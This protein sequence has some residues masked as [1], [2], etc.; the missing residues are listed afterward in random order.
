MIVLMPFTQ[1]FSARTWDWAQVLLVGAI[2][3]PGK[4]TVTAALRVLGLKDDKQYQNY[5]RVLN[6]AKWSG[7]QVSQ[8]LLGILV[9]TFVG[10]GVPIVLGADETLERRRGTKIK[11]KGIFRDAVRSSHKYTNYSSGLRWV[12]MMLLVSVPWS[13][14]VGA[15]PFLT[16]LAPSPKTNESNGRRHKTSIDWVGQMVGVVRRWLRQRELVLVV[17]GAMAAVKLGLRCAGYVRPVILVTRL[18]LDAVLHR[19]P[20]PQPKSKRGP[21]PKKGAR[22]P[23]LAQVLAG[24]ATIWI[25]QNIAWYG[26]RQRLIEYVTGTALWYTPGYDPLPIRW[27]LVRDPLGEFKPTAFFTTDQTAGPVQILDWFIMRWGLEVTFEEV[28]AHLGLETQR[29]WSGTSRPSQPSLM[30]LLWSGI[31]FGQP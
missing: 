10:V 24:P 26:G 11:A 18:R 20:G 27:V 4:R 7:L 14:R 2:L 15:L 5:H 19:P 6:R 29:Q 25:K 8:I 12:S 31:I 13:D 16:V 17:D 28:R 23:A 9:S 3:A 1:A 30:Q 21:K 22:L